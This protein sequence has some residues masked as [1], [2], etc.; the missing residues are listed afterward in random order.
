MRKWFSAVL[1]AKRGPSARENPLADQLS[2]RCALLGS[3]LAAADELS[4]HFRIGLEIRVK[5]RVE[6][7]EDSRCVTASRH[8]RTKHF[9]DRAQS[10]KASPA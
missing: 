4:P 1:S 2:V 6:H 9:K 7:Q 8:W 10:A 5:G 3:L